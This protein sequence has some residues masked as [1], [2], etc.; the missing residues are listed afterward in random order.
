MRACFFILNLIFLAAVIGLFAANWKYRSTPEDEILRWRFP[1][2]TGAETPAKEV[3]E[4]SQPALIR[5]KN[6]FSPLRESEPAVPP[7]GPGRKNAPPRFEL[8]GIC[9]IGDSSGAIINIL[10]NID[11]SREKQ[12]RYFAQGEDV[13]GGFILESVAESTIVLKRQ[14]ETLEVKID[15]SRF[16]AEIDKNR[17]LQPQRGTRGGVTRRPRRRPIAVEGSSSVRTGEPVPQP[18]TTIK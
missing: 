1:D 4:I 17:E 10:G 11:G 9:S 15:R 18:E 5:S 16:R 3:R 8:V 14:N 6:I 13:D 7:E 12:R 2:M